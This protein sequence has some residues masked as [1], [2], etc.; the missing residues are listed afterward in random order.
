M[1]MIKIVLENFRFLF[2]GSFLLF[3]IFSMAQ[4]GSFEIR[5]I[6]YDSLT[7]DLYLNYSKEISEASGILN[8]PEYYYDDLIIG[9]NPFFGTTQFHDGSVVYRGQRFENQEIGYDI[10]RDEVFISR[11]D[12]NRRISKINL[13]DDDVSAFEFSGRQFIHLNDSGNYENF[14]GNGY[15]ELLYSGATKV[16]AQ[17]SK[18][19]TPANDGGLYKYQF[20]IADKIFIYKENS[21]HRIFFKRTLNTLLK[22]EKKSWKP[23]IREN[24]QS[25]RDL[26]AYCIGLCQYYDSLK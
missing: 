9:G 11:Y 5:N 19:V 7:Q 6:T 12:Q 26:E 20:Q 17:R 2:T 3:T 14:P 24:G 25:L 4:P 18:K 13:E 16:L 1:G 8:G 15:Y 10:Y 22:D 23:F 21:F